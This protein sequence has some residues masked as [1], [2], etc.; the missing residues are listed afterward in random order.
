MLKNV[1]LNLARFHLEGMQKKSKFSVSLEFMS[2]QKGAIAPGMSVK[3]IVVFRCDF[4]EEA[5]ENVV[6]RVQGGKPVVI[7][8][9][10]FRDPPIL[11][12]T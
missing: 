7:P 6:V 12:G 11:Q 10:A 5:E 9:N 2:S 1:S 4:L 8:I 3:L